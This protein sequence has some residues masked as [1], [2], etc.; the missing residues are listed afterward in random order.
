MLVVN[1]GTADRDTPVVCTVMQAAVQQRKPDR[2]SQADPAAGNKKTEAWYP[3]YHQMKT[4]GLVQTVNRDRKTISPKLSM[5]I[6]IVC[7]VER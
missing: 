3:S 1:D 2:N 4:L 7:K 6:E 5:D